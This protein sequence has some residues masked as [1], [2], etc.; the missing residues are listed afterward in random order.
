[1][2]PDRRLRAFFPTLSFILGGLA[3]LLLWTQI[4]LFEK[5]P[6]ISGMQGMALWPQP[7]GFG[8]DLSALRILTV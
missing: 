7:L 2:R 6:T 4:L 3:H 5:R 8:A 1:M